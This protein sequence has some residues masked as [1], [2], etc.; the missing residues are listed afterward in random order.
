MNVQK[1]RGKNCNLNAY[2]F[3][4]G[5]TDTPDC[6]CNNGQ[7]TVQHFLLSCELYKVNRL[8]YLE[9]YIKI[10]NSVE[11]LLFDSPIFTPEQNSIKLWMVAMYTK[12]SGKEL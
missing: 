11:F 7:E 5:F 10:E 8:E 6:Y 4:L 9:T 12:I 1:L 3:A 2:N